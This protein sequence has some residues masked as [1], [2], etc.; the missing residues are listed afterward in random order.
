MKVVL[1]F[2]TCCVMN[3]QNLVPNPSFETSTSCFFSFG[4][5]YVASSWSIPANTANSS[6]DYFNPCQVEGL[7]RVPANIFGIQQAY[8]GSAYAGIVT[9][10]SST[11]GDYREYIQTQLLSPL[12]AGQ[13]YLVSYYVSPADYD[14]YSSNNI[15]AALTVQ[16]IVGDGTLLPLNATP[17]IVQQ[18]VVSNFSGWTLVS[19]TYL[20]VGN[21]QYLTIGNFANDAATQAV[22]SNPDAANQNEAY[23]YIDNVSVVQSGLS[24]T[25]FEEP[26]AI[27]YPNP[28]TDTFSIVSSNTYLIKKIELYSQYN[29]VKILNSSDTI[30]YTKDLSAGIYYLKIT[31]DDNTTKTTKLIKL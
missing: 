28:V 8:E 17:Q 9:Y 1:L 12:V 21:E 30:F 24:N 5:I 14:E 15:N 26:K 31:F 20:A 16:P 6:P 11:P 27:V 18:T 7:L 19:G 4:Q 10:H 3:A 23:Y 2:L 29:K 25:E 22:I 13:Q